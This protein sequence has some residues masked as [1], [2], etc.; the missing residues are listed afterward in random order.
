MKGIDIIIEKQRLM[1]AAYLWTGNNC[2]WYGRCQINYRNDKAVP[3]VL[4]AGTNNYTEVLFDDTRDA[5]SFFDVLPD[6]T[7]DL[8]TV[9]IYFAVKLSKLF[10]SI[11]ER[12]TEWVLLDVIKRLH[13]GG[14]FIP[15]KTKSIT[16]GY[17]A[18]KQWSMVKKEDNMQPFYLFKIKTNVQY[19]LTC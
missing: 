10:P 2:S 16:D 7:E 4:N 5:I 19:V 9:D 18:W 17:E 13:Q 11:T 8:A 3:E 6:R 15:D 1:F 14:L 12:A